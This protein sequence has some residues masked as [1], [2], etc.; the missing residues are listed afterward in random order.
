MGRG[1]IG[2]RQWP[3]H[4]HAVPAGSRDCCENIRL[5]EV[6]IH[7]HDRQV[8]VFERSRS[9]GFAKRTHRLDRPLDGMEPAHEE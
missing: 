6:A 2:P 3:D 1:K 9:S 8:A 4:M 7:S 5:R